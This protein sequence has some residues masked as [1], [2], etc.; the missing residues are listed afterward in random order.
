MNGSHIKMKGT[1]IY[2]TI[3]IHDTCL[4][5]WQFYVEVI[6]ALG[7]FLTNDW[8][9]TSLEDKELNDRAFKNGDERIVAK[10]KTS[11]GDIFIIRDA[12][13]TTSTILFADEY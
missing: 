8:G 6:Q 7:K 1:H 11:L 2:Q 10:Y 13:C 9:D 5:D 12:D 4:K 3:R